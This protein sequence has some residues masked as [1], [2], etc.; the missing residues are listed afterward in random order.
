MAQPTEKI[1]RH[2]ASI[3]QKLQ[4]LAE[5]IEGLEAAEVEAA[6]DEL[7]GFVDFLFGDLKPHAEGEERA[8]YPAVDAL[9]LQHGGRPTETMSL[10]HVAI[11][12]RLEAFRAAVEKV[13][14]AP[15]EEREAALRELRRAAHYIDALVPLHLH[16]E[17]EALLPYL[18]AHL[19]AEEVDAIV[20]QMHGH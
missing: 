15:A 17:E 13:L 3:S 11:T 9:I 6:R 4:R 1:R 10:E 20:H 18:D 12:E 8:L 16:G 14:A 7:E 2:H 19:S 5:R